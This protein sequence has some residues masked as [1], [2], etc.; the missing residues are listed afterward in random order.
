[1]AESPTFEALVGECIYIH[2]NWCS[3]IRNEIV[4]A[5]IILFQYL[6]LFLRYNTIELFPDS[7]KLWDNFF[8]LIAWFYYLSRKKKWKDLKITEYSFW[9]GEV[10]NFCSAIPWGQGKVV[11]VTI[12]QML[13]RIIGNCTGKGF[14]KLES[15][16]WAWTIFLS[17]F[18]GQKA[19]SRET[20]EII[21]LCERGT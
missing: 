12:F 15:N 16:W 20:Y 14:Y 7:R 1:M 19:D 11:I 17:E 5:H 8:I 2:F 10:G 3:Q 21:E 9:R 18:N 4:T 13:I 6:I